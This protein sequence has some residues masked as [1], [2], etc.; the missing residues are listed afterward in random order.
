MGERPTAEPHTRSIAGILGPPPR[1][2][3]PN[4][5]WD[6]LVEEAAVA[7]YFADQ[8]RAWGEAGDDDDWRPPQPDTPDGVTAP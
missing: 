7:E 6:D 3:D 4:R 5:S 1:R 2:P 8:R